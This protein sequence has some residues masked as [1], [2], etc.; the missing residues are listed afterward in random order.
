MSE[1]IKK[2]VP[3]GW[4]PYV[5]PG[6]K[7]VTLGGMV[8]ADVHGKNHYKDG[9]FGKY[10]DWIE[11]IGSK[12][13]LIKC[14]SK[15]NTQLYNWTIGGMGLT[16]II[17]K[18]AFR[19]KKIETCWMYQKIYNTKNLDDTIEIFE[20]NLENTY[21]VAW[22][23]CLNKGDKLGKSIIF[24]GNHLKLKELPNKLKKSPLR[25]VNKKK[26]NVPL[27][28]PNWFLNNYLIKK[29]NSFYYFL[30]SFKKREVLDID[31]FFYPLDNILNWNKLYGKK[32]FSQFQCVLPLD[33][34]KKALKEM[35]SLISKSDLNP[36]LAV[37]KRFGDQNS[38]FSFPMKG[39]TL[40]ID[41]PITKKNLL[42]MKKLDQL[43]IKFKGRIY[44]A[45]DNKITKQ[46]FQKL[47]KRLKQFKI[48]RK[49]NN[50]SNLFLSSQSKR[51]GL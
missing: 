35:L 10:L 3:K 1:I 11:I 15:K 47:E 19:L 20:K 29:F 32:G 46:K 43:T 25:Y 14:S 34:S 16:G 51:L 48:Y 12:G 37:L 8:A 39:Y 45:K 42:L 28:F 24:S 13:K 38:F 4:F 18:I 44:L 27:F 9:S 17:T 26:F 36:F 22:I 30:N 21:T 41:F 7:Y 23:D 49:K 31:K 50:L 2:F 5:T 6:S 33:N 40:A